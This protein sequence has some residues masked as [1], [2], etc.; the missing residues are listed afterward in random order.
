MHIHEYQG[1]A[2]LKEFGVPVL[3]GRVVFSTQEAQDAVG[4]FDL[5]QDGVVIKAQ[6]HAGGRGK[7]GGVKIAKDV[8]SFERYVEGILNNLLVTAQTKP[9]GQMVRSLYLEE[10]C[11][12]AKE[13][14][15]SLVLDRQNKT[16]TAIAS[17]E[18]G[19]NIEDIAEKN[20]E[21]VLSMSIHPMVGY[22]PFHGR[23]LASFLNVEKEHQGALMDL[24]KGLYQA[25]TTLDAELIEI[26]PL[27]FTRDEKWIALDA[28]MTFDDN[29]LARQKRVAL[30]EDTHEVDPAELRAKQFDLN[31]VKLDGNIGCMVNGAG[32]AMATM[33][34]IARHGGMPANFLDV[35]G[36][37]T[38]E[39]VAEAFKIIAADTEVKAIF[40]NIFGGI[41]RCDIIAEGIIDAAKDLN[42][43][44]PLVVRLQG[45]HV[46]RG[47]QLLQESGLSITAEDDFDTAAMNVVSAG[48]GH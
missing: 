16:I 1:K 22:Q 45:T 36:G 42:L 38:K 27:V 9:E 26:N 28:K 34:I 29:S 47:R 24:L 35:G 37:A 7:G 31:Y 3:G 18:G 17:S 13:Y 15:L 30:L 41:M 44:L 10:T 20:P 48:R 19:M 32:L 43:S 8:T 6:I 11:D 5:E 23:R 46:E 2:L 40:V 12:I 14:Y 4:D 39:R 21:K 25:F 33:D